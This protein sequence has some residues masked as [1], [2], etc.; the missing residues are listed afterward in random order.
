MRLIFHMP[1]FRQ[2]NFPQTRYLINMQQFLSAQRLR[3]NVLKGYIIFYGAW[4][5]DTFYNQPPLTR[6]IQR[7]I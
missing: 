7:L 1:V 6:F 2:S 5:K 3:T 4:E